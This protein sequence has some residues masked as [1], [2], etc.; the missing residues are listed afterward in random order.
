MIILLMI[1]CRA[2]LVFIHPFLFT[3]V[4]KGSLDFSKTLI[5]PNDDTTVV[6]IRDAPITPRTCALKSFHFPST[7][8]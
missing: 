1:S 6:R 4:P 3:G 7:E 2:L 5:S 8:L